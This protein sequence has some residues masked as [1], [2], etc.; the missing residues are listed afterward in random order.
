[1]ALE[2]TAASAALERWL[3]SAAG[4]RRVR[5]TRYERLSGGAIQDNW[6]LDAAIDGG[7]W[8]GEQR[9]VLRTDAPSTVA[10][11]LTRAQEFAV[12]RVAHAAGVATPEPLWLCRDSEVLGREFFIMRRIAGVGQAHRL[13][14]EPA[15]VPDPEGLVRALG[16]NLARIHAIRPGAAELGVLPASPADPARASIATIRAYLDDFDDA[17]PALEW[18]LRRCER[19]APPAFDITLIHGDYR[20]G[21]YLVEE[22]RLTGVLD[23][24]FA[25]WGDPRQDIGWFTA[26]CWRSHGVDLEAGGLAAA[27]PFLEGYAAVSGRRVSRDELDYWQAMAHVRWAVIALQQARRHTSGGERSLELALTGRIVHELEL[28]ALRLID[29]GDA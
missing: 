8:H 25:G 20:T 17:Y 29:R 7:A 1:M 24:E 10:S 21:N 15:L 28:E 23:W 2:Q 6:T 27:E 4:A 3:C 12:L 19:R 18:S 13:T 22:G 16:A 14:R 11:S 26:R 5:V 9:F